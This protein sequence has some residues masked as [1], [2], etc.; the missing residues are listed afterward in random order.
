[1]I[2]EYVYWGLTS[3][4]GAQAQRCS[5]IEHE[6][7][8]CTSAALNETDPELVTLL[9]NPEF[10]LPNV[11]PD[12]DY[13]PVTS[14]SLSNDEVI[15]NGSTDPVTYDPCA[16]ESD[17]DVGPWEGNKSLNILADGH[18]LGADAWQPFEFCESW[19]NGTGEAIP[20]MYKARYD[21]K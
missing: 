16:V 10:N 13:A 20:T 18:A 9:T 1:M 2:T 15:D 7:R 3:M 5:E 21:I 8:P 12:G 19:E 14:T 11:L 4:L 6:W 17:R